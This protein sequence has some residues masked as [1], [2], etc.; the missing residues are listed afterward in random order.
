[1]PCIGDSSICEDLC[2]LARVSLMEIK[3]CSRDLPD[4]AQVAEEI[5]RHLCT[6]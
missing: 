3:G 1:M 6:E 4:G 2:G 5:L